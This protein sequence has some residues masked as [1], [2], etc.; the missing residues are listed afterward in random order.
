MQMY[1]YQSRAQWVVGLQKVSS[2]SGWLQQQ[3]MLQLAKCSGQS[4]KGGLLS[5]HGES[6]FAIAVVQ[7][8]LSVGE[9][10]HY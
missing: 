6:K 1:G 9:S 7:Y 2:A 10:K 8:V 3:D 4:P 5:T